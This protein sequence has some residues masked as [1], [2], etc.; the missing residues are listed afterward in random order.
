MHWLLDTWIVLWIVLGSWKSWSERYILLFQ[1][2]MLSMKCTLLQRVLFSEY[3][4]HFHEWLFA[5]REVPDCVALIYIH[6]FYISR[7]RHL[8]LYRLIASCN[9]LSMQNLALLY[10]KL[11]KIEP[12]KLRLLESQIWQA[13]HKSTCNGVLNL[14]LE[15]GLPFSSESTLSQ[16]H[17]VRGVMQVGWVRCK[18]S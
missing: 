9:T 14:N 5:G 13:Q 17:S 11:A 4:N 1:E 18:V 10:S 2:Q 3:V 6:I 12:P 16:E 15:K 7:G 8:A